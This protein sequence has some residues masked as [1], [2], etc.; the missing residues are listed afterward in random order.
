MATT[1]R[2]GVR[3]IG[4]L[5]R[6]NPFQLASLADCYAPDEG[7]SR[8]KRTWSEGAKFLVSVRDAVIEAIRDGYVTVDDRDDRG[9]LHEIADDAPD[10]Y[11]HAR[12]KQ[13]VD[14]GAFNEEPEY[15][16]EWPKDLTQMAGVALYQIADRL[17]HALVDAW[18]EA[19]G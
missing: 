6:L 14:L 7:R 5:T 19:R 3:G 4:A 17:C 11:T 8:R 15:G 9:Q 12:W 1:R 16:D 10:I 13:F 18:I 2:N